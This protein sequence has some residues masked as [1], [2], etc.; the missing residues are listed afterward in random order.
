MGHRE[1]RNLEISWKHVLKFALFPASTFLGLFLALHWFRIHYVIRVRVGSYTYNYEIQFPNFSIYTKNKC[2]HAAT[3]N[4]KMMEGGSDPKQPC[5]KRCKGLRWWGC[6]ASAPW[7]TMWHCVVAK[8]K[9]GL[10]LFAQ[11]L[12]VW[13][14]HCILPTTA[15]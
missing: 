4:G 13:Q 6:I 7:W 2:G 14:P 5:I 15:F 12:Y 10:T 9:P 8:I 11:S 3:R 1:T